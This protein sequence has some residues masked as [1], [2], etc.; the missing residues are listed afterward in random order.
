MR[1]QKH[2]VA[3]FWT[4]L[5]NAVW[6]CIQKY[7]RLH[8]MLTLNMHTTKELE[9]LGDF[10]P[11]PST[12]ALHL[13]PTF[14]S[15]TLWLCYPTRHPTRHFMR[16]L[17]F[18]KMLWAKFLCSPIS[19]AYQ[20]FGDKEY[21]YYGCAAL[22]VA[23]DIIEMPIVF[24]YLS[25]ICAYTGWLKKVRCILW[26]IFQQSR[27]IFIK[28]FRCYTYQEICNKRSLQIPPHLSGVATLL[29][30]ILMSEN[31]AYPIPCG[32]VF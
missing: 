13:D 27:I 24:L 12:V 23:I 1:W 30:E 21:F 11:R 15:Q 28:L 20:D 3:Y 22:R 32:T 5:Y 26:W 14:V 8:E 2:L 7:T 9:L 6:K 17:I 29:C 31:I 19:G 16:L 18:L 10:V 4:T 25:R